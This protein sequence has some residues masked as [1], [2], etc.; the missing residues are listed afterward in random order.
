[1]SGV[2]R[3]SD[4]PLQTY[5]L[6]SINEFLQMET[7]T[8]GRPTATLAESQTLAL[9]NEEED[10][11]VALQSAYSFAKK[12]N[13]GDAP[14]RYS[15][16]SR[17]SKKT[18]DATKSLV[19]AREEKKAVSEVNTTARPG[20]YS[21]ASQ[22]VSQRAGLAQRAGDVGDLREDKSGSQLGA[23]SFSNTQAQSAS[24]SLT[25][26]RRPVVDIRRNH[27][28]QIL[29]EDTERFKV[30]LDELVGKFRLETLTEFMAAKKHLLDEQASAIGQER[31]VT[32]SRY[33][34][35]CF[36]VH[37]SNQAIRGQRSTRPKAI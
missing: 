5:S 20:D 19:S 23:L 37:S 1:M 35:K 15:H 27:H 30:R 34:S 22:S 17:E 16:V 11:F 6:D 2:H 10:Q 13:K 7:A 4:V 25:D 18:T 31:T 21:L 26:P 33:Q 14:V 24:I 12:D 3:L 28:P 36:E 32:D 29:D 9:A 8:K